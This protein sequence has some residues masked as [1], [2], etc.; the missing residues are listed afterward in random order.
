MAKY[1][2]SEREVEKRSGV[3][4]KTINNMR[5]AKHKVTVEN[6]DTVASVF[7]LDGWQLLVHD[8][9]E[10]LLESSSF[11]SMIS[12]YA[13]SGTDGRTAIDRTAEREAMY[14]ETKKAE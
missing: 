7:N 9:P 4:A 1:G 12:N 11:R 3:S 8:L 6:A 2:Y 13:R 10:D 14:S 5:N